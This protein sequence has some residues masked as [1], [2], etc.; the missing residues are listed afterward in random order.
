LTSA[1]VAKTDPTE[2][3]MQALGEKIAAGD[4][5]ALDELQVTSEMLYKNIDYQ[6]DRERVVGNLKLMKAAF[7]VLGVKAAAGDAHSL[8]VLKSVLGTGRLAAFASGA[9][10]D[11]AGDGN[12]EALDVL[13]N[14]QKWGITESSAISALY[15]AVKNKNEKAI[16][17]LLAVMDDPKSRGLWYMASTGLKPAAD[18]GNE[19]AIA[20]IEKYNASK[21]Q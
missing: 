10:G 11:A 14:Y 12:A 3:D 19:K 18:D 9:I 21:N 5:V 8:E 17:F 6:A 7:D 4:E 13:L 15:P 16:D 2:D 1:A 20:A